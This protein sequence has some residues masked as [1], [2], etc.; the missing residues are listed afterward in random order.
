MS[1]FHEK[2]DLVVDGMHCTNCAI[3]LERH[4]AALGVASPK[5]DFTSSRASG[6]LPHELSLE[7]VVAEIGRLGYQVQ[8]I[9]RKSGG[10]A[11][12]SSLEWQFA[13]C[14]LW[15]LPL[16][17]HMFLPFHSLHNAWVQFWLCTPVYLV[18]LRYFGRSAL[19]SIKVG[20]PSMDVLILIGSSAAY[21]YSL[22]GAWLQLGEQFLFFETAATIITLVLLGNVIEKY[23][24]RRT[25][26]AL[27]ELAKLQA[28]KAV[29]IESVGGQEVT[30]EVAIED[31]KI[32]DT[33]R[34]NTG[35]QVATDGVIVAGS[36]A[37]DESTIT[38]ESIPVSKTNGDQVIGGTLLVQGSLKMKVSAVGSAT[39]LAR[40]IELVRDAQASKPKIQRLG[41][42]VSAIFTPIVVC[43]AVATIIGSMIWGVDPV[44][45]MLR[46]IAVLVIACPCAMGLATPTAVAVALGRA[47]RHGVLIKGA[48]TLEELSAVRT[49]VFDKTGT[50]TSGT[51]Q[52]SSLSSLLA[53]P[54]A[55]ESVVAGLERHS[56]HPIAKSLQK[57]YQAAPRLEFSKVEETRGLGIRGVTARGDRY[58]L[59]R[60]DRNGA[61]DLQLLWNDQPAAVLAIEDAVR[62]EAAQAV[63]ALSQD[64]FEVVML[65]GDKREKCESV[66]KKIG[67][68]RVLAE[69]MPEQK[70]AAISE[71]GGA[72]GVAFVGDGINDSPALARARVGISLSEATGAAVQSAQIILLDRDLMK[73]PWVAR[74]AKLTL[75]TI[76]QNLFWAFFYNAVAIPV[77]ALG[78]LNPM[79]AALTMALSDVVVIGN[80]IRLRYR[81]I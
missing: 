72:Q 73:V 61:A 60:A 78:Y 69:Q 44:Q 41:D 34:L 53:I 2:L 4:L 11:S 15:T 79:V 75:L 24:V 67:I 31:V 63:T 14:A 56:S 66:A 26:S 54:D 29:R 12:L 49:I 10:L 52:V 38:G 7:R 6:D 40:M 18:G 42:K 8:G 1:H 59:R 65:S 25:T 68:S 70:L 50:L 5:V 58:E 77:A 33:L 71:L 48:P 3:G 22:A 74:L 21:I 20:M 28:T 35:D 27:R 45:A 36:A 39:L 46:G 9:G 51:F 47:A 62:N 43:V 80:S 30:T 57:I 37:I 17:L 64:K 55:V 23:A 32:G 16:L 19:A 13:W 76:R 81:K